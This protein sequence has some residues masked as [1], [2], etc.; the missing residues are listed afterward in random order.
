[1]D[2]DDLESLRT[3]DSDLDAELDDVAHVSC[4]YCGEASELSVDPGGGA[5]QEYVEDCEVCC[6]PWLVR[7]RFDGEGQASVIV[8]T[9]DDE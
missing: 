8:A 1:M 5:L 3:Y 6:Q 9:L 7:V 2:F 4:P